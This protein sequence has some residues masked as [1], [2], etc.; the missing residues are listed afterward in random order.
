AAA[1]IKQ[2]RLFLAQSINA[3]PEEIIFTSGATEANNLAIKGVAEAYFTKGKHL[4][5]VQTEHS[6]VLAPCRYLES[7]GFRVTY[8][9]VKSNGLLDLDILEKAIEADTILVSVMAANNEIGVLQGIAEIG[10]ICHHHQVLFHTDAAQAFT[11][12][13]LNVETMNIDLMSLTAHKIYGPT[14]I[15]ALYCR[16]KTPKVN[17]ASQMQ[18]GGQEQG[19]RSGTLPTP[20]IIGFA[21]AARLAVGELETENQRLKILRD[22]LWLGLQSIEGII[23]NGDLENRLAGNL[24]VSIEGVNGTNLLLALQPHLALSSGSACSALK[25]QASPVLIALG[26][27]LPLAQ[28]SLRLGVGRFTTETEIEQAI[29]VITETVERLRRSDD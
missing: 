14:G 1:A 2:A 11:K 20:L 23:L 6:A 3:Q 17:L 8:L 25:K 5:T 18:G 21:E 15:G 4:I 9:P 13:K 28:A 12:I 24:N 26:R 22:R 16:R 7:L 29:A 10:K 19:L 27:S